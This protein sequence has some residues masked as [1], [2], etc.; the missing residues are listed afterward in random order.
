MLKFIH[1]HPGFKYEIDRLIQDIVA[2]CTPTYPIQIPQDSIV[3][4][5][6][7]AQMEN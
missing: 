5:M 6:L 2:E 3:E 7:I 4:P 1:E